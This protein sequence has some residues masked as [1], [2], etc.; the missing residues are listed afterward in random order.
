M[1]KSLFVCMVIGAFA[2]SA[3]LADASL[4]QA[5]NCTA[6]HAPAAK[7]VGPSFKD[8]AAKYA[9]QADAENKLVDKVMKGSSGAWG[10]AM[11]PNPQVSQAEAHTLVKWILSQ[12]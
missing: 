3:A 7:L 2:S 5:K 9:G 8:V 10:G 11:P 1:K 12:K 4:A 6:C